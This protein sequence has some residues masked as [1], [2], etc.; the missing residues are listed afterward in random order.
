MKK[1]VSLILTLAMVFAMSTTALADTAHVV[2]THGEN[3]TVADGVIGDNFGSG[4]V[5]ETEISISVSA[6]ST[7][8]RYAVDVE[9]S[10]IVVS[11]SGAGMTWDVNNLEYVITDDGEMEQPVPATITV[12]NYSDQPVYVSAT[13]A[14][15]YDGTT[16]DDDG[17]TI[18]ATVDGGAELARATAKV[19]S[20]PGSAA[21]KTVT[22]SFSTTGDWSAVAAFYTDKLSSS[23][24][25]LQIATVNLTIAKEAP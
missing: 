25:T 16:N 18:T 12:K 9:Y 20:T 13:V 24:P 15:L 23:N 17:M 4:A 21:T 3:G 7:Q 14:D 2:G 5:P 11:I 10:E 6:G 1:V 22:V 19:G 8:S